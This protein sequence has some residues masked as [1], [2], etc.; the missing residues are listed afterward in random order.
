MMTYHSIKRLKLQTATTAKDITI[1]CNLTHF[2]AVNSL[3]WSGYYQKIMVSNL[4]LNVNDTCI[5]KGNPQSNIS[6][7]SVT[8]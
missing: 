7:D 4:K 3:T 2:N 5:Q 6:R 8:E 1:E